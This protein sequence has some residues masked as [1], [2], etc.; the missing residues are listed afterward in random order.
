MLDLDINEAGK[1]VSVLIL[2]LNQK[3]CESY[4]LDSTENE[5]GTIDKEFKYGLNFMLLFWLLN[6]Y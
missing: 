3:R 2:I 4:I 6:D 5:F 1:E